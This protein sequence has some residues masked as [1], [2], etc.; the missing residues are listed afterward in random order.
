MFQHTAARRRLRFADLTTGVR[1][2]FQHTAARRRLHP[3]GDGIGSVGDVS[4]HSRTKAAASSDLSKRTAFRVSTHSRT[5][6]AA[7]ERWDTLSRV[8]GFNT[9]PH[10]GGCRGFNYEKS[11]IKSFNTQPHEGGCD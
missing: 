9:Q 4:T 10:E 7:G 8:T 11:V 2:E 3:N 6:A 1:I 5:K